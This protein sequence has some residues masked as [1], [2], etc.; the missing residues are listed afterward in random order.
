MDAE[1]AWRFGLTWGLGH[2]RVRAYLRLTVED[3][4]GEAAVA[5]LETG[6]V[7]ARVLIDRLRRAYGRIGSARHRGIGLPVLDEPITEEEDTTRGDLLLAGDDPAYEE[8]E[9][10]L[11]ARRD[12]RRLA[13]SLSLRERWVVELKLD[14]RLN[15]EI[16]AELGV[17]PSRVSQMLR[18]IEAAF[19]AAA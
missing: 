16:A 5:Y 14:G 2:P 19:R 7:S 8:L 1:R 12:L 4:A 15:Q 13:R 18:R 17:T 10:R 6:D 3:V 11:D 9:T